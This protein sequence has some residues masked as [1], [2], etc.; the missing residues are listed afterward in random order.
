MGIFDQQHLRGYSK[1]EISVPAPGPPDKYGNCYF[2]VA[3]SKPKMDAQR[4]WRTVPVMWK[5]RAWLMNNLLPLAAF[6]EILQVDE[7]WRQ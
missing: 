6:D 5:K 7:L 2:K 1:G 3:E 4:A